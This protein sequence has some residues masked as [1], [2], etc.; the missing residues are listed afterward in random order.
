MQVVNSAPSRVAKALGLAILP[1][2]IA[3]SFAATA[4]AAASNTD[5]QLQDAWRE[6]IRTTPTPSEG[7]FT[8]SYPSRAWEKVTC[9][10]KPAIPYIPRR[11]HGG[12]TVGNGYDYSALVTSVIS[13]GVGSFPSVTGVTKETDFGE[14]NTYSLQLNSQF[15]N[16]PSCNGHSGCLGWQQFVYSSSEGIAFMQYWLINYGKTCPSGGGWNQYSGS[17]Y[18]NSSEVSVPLQAITQLGNLKVTGAAASGGSDTVT[19]TTASKAYS[20]SGPDTVTHLANYWNEG[21]FNVIGDGG[22]S[23]AKFNKGAK[24]SVKIAL[25]DGSTSAPT[26]N[27]PSNGGTTGE[28]NNL[29]LGSCTGSGGSTPSISF[30]ES[31]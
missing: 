9:S 7:C 25:T 13:S 27:G 31:D 11:G 6:A 18:K 29:N 21:E 12:F 16:S 19:L 10:D 20:A 1:G 14:P 2:A 17:C 23:K 24:L 5:A 26:C 15:F 3:L 30:T 22:G 4:Q 8:A 28:T